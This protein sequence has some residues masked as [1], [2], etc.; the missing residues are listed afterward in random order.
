M[1]LAS[2]ATAMPAAAQSANA[3]GPWYVGIGAG[4]SHSTGGNGSGV[5]SGVPFTVSGLEGNQ[6]SWQINGGY[7]F[8]PEWGVE[9]QYTDLGDRD[10]SVTFGAPVNGT[11]SISGVKA[12]Q[13]GIAATGTLWFTD[14]FFGRAKLGVSSNHIDSASGTV[15][16]AGGTGTVNISSGSKTDVLAGIAIGYKWTPNISSRLEYE[17]FGKFA[18]TPTGDIKG[19]NLGLRLQ[20]A[21]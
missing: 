17:Y 9:V 4:K 7:Q 16:T 2:A 3:A 13:W 14:S 8:T 19:S 5:V 18:S 10:G 12:Y 15:T 6:T 21:F 20:Y 11:A 1:A